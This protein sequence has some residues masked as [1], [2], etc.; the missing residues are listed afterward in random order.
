MD[1]NIPGS[2]IREVEVEKVKIGTAAKLILGL[3][4]QAY[5]SLS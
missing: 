5:S 4:M 3:L 2:E 1:A